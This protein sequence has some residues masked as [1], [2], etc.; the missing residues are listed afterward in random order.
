MT[1]K[2][3][4]CAPTICPKHTQHSLTTASGKVQDFKTAI[5]FYFFLI[6]QLKWVWMKYITVLMPKTTIHF[7]SESLHQSMGYA[8]EVL[9]F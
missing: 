5:L 3:H 4:T 8:V 2:M 1:Y 9:N 7:P 6:C